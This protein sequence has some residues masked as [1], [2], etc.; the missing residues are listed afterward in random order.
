[1]AES[2]LHVLY[3]G[4]NLRFLFQWAA[5][6]QSKLKAKY[7]LLHSCTTGTTSNFLCMEFFEQPRACLHVRLVGPVWV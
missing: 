5:C 3:A 7:V 4:P 1:M 6:F 2:C